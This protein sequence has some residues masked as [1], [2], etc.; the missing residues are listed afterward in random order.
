MCVCVCVNTGYDY[1]AVFVPWEI[2]CQP[3]ALDT[4]LEE[5]S[6]L[7]VPGLLFLSSATISC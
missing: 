2:I 5:R 4:V 6:S 7:A 3:Q 1:D